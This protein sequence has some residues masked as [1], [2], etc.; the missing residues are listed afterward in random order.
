MFVFDVLFNLLAMASNLI[1][2][3]GLHSTGGL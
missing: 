3:D 1:N 2:N